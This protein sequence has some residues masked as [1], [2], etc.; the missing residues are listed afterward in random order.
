MRGW[1]AG[2]GRGAPLRAVESEDGPDLRGVLWGRVRGGGIKEGGLGVKRR[3]G[4]EPGPLPSERPLSLWG[5]ALATF[6]RE[7]AGWVSARRVPGVLSAPPRSE[8]CPEPGLSSP[9]ARRPLLHHHAGPGQH[10]SRRPQVDRAGWRHRPHVDRVPQHRHGRQ[11]GARGP[12]PRSQAPR[13]TVTGRGACGIQHTSRPP[14]SAH[15]A[16]CGWGLRRGPVWSSAQ[17]VIDG[18]GLGE[19]PIPRHT[20]CRT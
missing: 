12:R 19:A 18:E 5:R 16:R 6:E 20:P 2:W 9:A 8:C 15:R 13:T 1:G 11:Q 3:A 10:H 7:G 14:H 4:S 17:S